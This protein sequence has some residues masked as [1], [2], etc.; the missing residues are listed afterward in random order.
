MRINS[1]TIGME[2]ARSY[3]SVSGRV[4]RLVITSGRQSLMDGTGTLL[5]NNSDKNT[6]G[7]TSDAKKEIVFV[8]WNIPTKGVE[9]LVSAWNNIGKQ[10]PDYWNIWTGR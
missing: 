3:S 7:E 4:S 1:G 8:G 2:S 9:E 6:E 5:G 10:F